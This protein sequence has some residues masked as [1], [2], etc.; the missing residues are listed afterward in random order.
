M[1]EQQPE[2]LR[3]ADEFDWWVARGLDLEPRL[4]DASAELRRLHAEVVECHTE[5]GNQA[6]K[7]GALF[8]ENFKL[9]AG[10]C[11]NVVGDEG[12]TPYCRLHDENAGLLEQNTALDKKLA[13]L[14]AINAQLLEALESA[15]NYVDNLGGSSQIYRQVIAVA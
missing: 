7:V 10:Q 1:R 8:D 3:L 15:S 11:L 13:E 4:A 12:G 2:A 6:K 9:A 5:I 14:E